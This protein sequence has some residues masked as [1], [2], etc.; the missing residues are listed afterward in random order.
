MAL[1]PLY[2]MT[3]W[4]CY[5]CSRSFMH[6]QSQIHGLVVAIR[7]AFSVESALSFS[8]CPLPMVLTWWMLD[9]AI[10]VRTTSHVHMYR[11][12][13]G[14]GASQLNVAW[15]VKASFAPAKSKLKTLLMFWPKCTGLLQGKHATRR[16]VTLTKTSAFWWKRRQGLSAVSSWYRRTLYPS[17]T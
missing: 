5:C 3:T 11:I 17:S 16:I 1:Y 15:T 2:S 7:A 4:L 10:Q 8:L 6:V 13:H 12:K 14:G 9:C